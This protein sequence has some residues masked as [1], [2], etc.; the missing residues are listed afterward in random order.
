VGSPKD[1]KLAGA[2]GRRVPVLEAAIYCGSTKSTF[3][4][5]R[6]TGGGPPFI[7]L[8]NGRVVYDTGDL[9]AWLA[10]RRRTSTADRPPSPSPTPQR[11]TSRKT[12]APA[13]PQKGGGRR[14]S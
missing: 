3:D 1:A 2:E 4:K 10:T 9:D 13:A 7:K 12:P 14:S 8:F 11:K 5:K 6:V